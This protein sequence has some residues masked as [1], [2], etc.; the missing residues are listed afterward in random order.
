MK[1]VIM[2]AALVLL[3][4]MSTAETCLHLGL[5]N[6]IFARERQGIVI[7]LYT[8]RLSEPRHYT[9]LR[10]NVG[11]SLF[12]RSAHDFSKALIGIETNLS[13]GQW[14]I[15]INFNDTKSGDVKFIAGL[16]IL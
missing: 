8:N 11:V 4:S 15:G 5:A 9:Q 13:Y 10:L 14:F 16:R 6:K 1:I 7:D 3:C 12:Q 2:I